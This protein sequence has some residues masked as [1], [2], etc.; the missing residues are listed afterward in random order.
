MD[1]DSV[2][3]TIY[4]GPDAVFTL[5]IN[6]QI[7]TQY[8]Y[9]CRQLPVAY[10]QDALRLRQ[11]DQEFKFLESISDNQGIL[12][13]SWDN[14]SDGN[15]AIIYDYKNYSSIGKI[16]K[17]CV[18][19][20]QRIPLPLTIKWSISLIV[21]LEQLQAAAAELEEP[22]IDIAIWPDTLFVDASG[23]LHITHFSLNAPPS[24]SSSIIKHNLTRYFLYSAPEQTIAGHT[25]DE[26]VLY[27]VLGMLLYELL[28][29]KPLFTTH[30]SID[31][32]QIVR[33]KLRKL[34]PLLSD[35]DSRLE[36][37]NLIVTELLTPNPDN[38]LAHL[39]PVKNKLLEFQQKLDIN[40]NQAETISFQNFKDMLTD[41]L[42]RNPLLGRN[43][44]TSNI[45]QF[46]AS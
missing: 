33:R 7:S 9:Y 38:R 23:N 10:Q 35:V 44:E 2:I 27:F 31:S 20:E 37:L 39:T 22:D 36:P 26:K 25:P 28:T 14:T 8:Y 16:V 19:A 40:D 11:F 12:K 5:C 45:N 43:F 24:I 17:D 42:E 21:I 3:E 18:S 34:H 41:S 46:N 1:T 30:T 13:G 29:S 15:P 4:S 6:E 32:K